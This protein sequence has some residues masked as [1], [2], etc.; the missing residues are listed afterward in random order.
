LKSF[1]LQIAYLFLFAI[2]ILTGGCN[3]Q[4][5]N[6]VSV[7]MQ[8]LTA[9]YNIIYNARALLETSEKNIEAAYVDDYEQFLSVYKEPTEISSK[10]ESKILDSVIQKT[11]SIVAEKIKSNYVDDA[12]FLKGKANYLKGNYF[13]SYEFFDYVYN[14][15][16]EEKELKQASL[17]WKARAQLQLNNLAKAAIA[18]DSAFKNINTEKK[19]VPGIYA[20][21]AQLYIKSGKETEAIKMLEE[22]LKFEKTK[23]LKIRWTYLLAQ[24]QQH[25]DQLNDAYENYAK[26]IQSNAPFEMAFNASLNRI[27]IEEK[28]SGQTGNQID[29]FKALLKDNKNKD[30][31]GQ[32]YYYIAQL[33]QERGDVEAAM[34]SY[35][36]AI[37]NSTKNQ[38]QQGLAYLQLAEIYF[39]NADYKHA[40]TYYDSTLTVLSPAYPNY[41]LIRLKSNNLD[42]LAN[43]LQTIAREDTLQMLARLPQADRDLYINSLLIAQSQKLTANTVSALKNPLVRGTAADSKFYFN[44][45]MALS[46]GYID[47]KLRW[48]NRKLEDNWRRG[49]KS[50][51]ETTNTITGPDTAKTG[52][53]N[54]ADSIALRK[55]YIDN[56]PLTPQQLEESN[57]KIANSYYDIANFYKDI[58]K[59]N[60]E[61]VKTYQELLKRYPGN[62]LNPAVYY[63]LYRLYSTSDPAKS[64]EYRDILVKKY[65]ETTFAKVILDPNYSQKADEKALALSEAYNIIYNLYT[66]KKYNELINKIAETERVFGPNPFSSQL[67]YLN[68]LA[69]GRTRDVSIF[70]KSL[71][72]IVESYPNDNLVT[73]LVKQNLEYI[74]ANRDAMSKRAYALVDSDPNESQFIEPKKEPVSQPQNVTTSRTIVTAHD[75]TKPSANLPQQ[76]ASPSIST[77]KTVIAK[78]S[79]FS[80]PDTSEYYYVI[81]VLSPG[82]NLASSRFGIGQFNRS[83][84]SNVKISHQLKEVNKENQLIFVGPFQTRYEAEEYQRSINP[85]MKDIMKIPATNYNNFIITKDGLNKLSTR[86]VINDYLEFY[87]DNNK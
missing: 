54:S 80:L 41:E 74:T 8:N 63:N 59:D 45:A 76:Q 60:D 32:I 85:L 48:G 38:Y 65:P 33:Y 11:N 46:Q 57:Q 44:N 21:R 64:A 29:R 2:V 30:F 4:K 56:L 83:N 58:L 87:S 12:Y 81:N 37:R 23:S 50:A 42:L 78:S 13:N 20:T 28:Q 66:E 84:Y 72:K 69:T 16:P 36:T 52:R 49:S 6:V 39:K 26:V 31:I 40:K 10:T 47:F 17:V 73:P 24:L 77:P 9:R 86:S 71:Q 34:K 18:L 1:I 61:A 62:S 55:S 7:R 79:I 75:I 25:N 35:N 70:E 15:Y 27:H 5:D 51:A 68:S 14:T 43:R 3:S 22:A 53:G 82:S 67:A 19:S